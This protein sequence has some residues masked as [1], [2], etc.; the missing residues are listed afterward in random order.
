MMFRCAYKK[1]VD[2][3]AHASRVSFEGVRLGGGGGASVLLDLF[4][5]EC[6]E[7]RESDRVLYELDMSKRSA[8]TCDD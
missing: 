3:A 6:R 1:K 2:V 4:G 5:F 8:A 7:L